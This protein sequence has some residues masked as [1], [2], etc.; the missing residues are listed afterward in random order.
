MKVISYSLY[1]D[2]NRYIEPLLFNAKNLDLFYFGWQIRVYHDSSVP[3]DKLKLLDDL[4][5]QLIDIKKTTFSHIGAKF[6]RFLPVFE[7]NIE[8]LVLRDSDSIF[9]QREVALVHDWENSNL[10]FHIIRDHALHIS[11]ILAG[12]FGVK[13]NLFCFFKDHISQNKLVLSNRYNADQQF[14]A[15]Y[16]YSKIRHNCMIHTSHFAFFGENYIR[17]GKSTK[18][19][20]FIGAVYT[21]NI[22]ENNILHYDFI[23]GIPF[24]GAKLLRYKIR[25]VL[26][27][28]YFFN[29]VLRLKIK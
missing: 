10:N 28:S 1:G 26:Y 7:N 15:D 24:W 14:L 18:A 25:P 27:L 4:G 11:P 16:I 21:N 5:V 29:L 12:M 6:W 9:S 8:I 19:D 22:E 2:L 23:V 3:V 17:I 20:D 13:K